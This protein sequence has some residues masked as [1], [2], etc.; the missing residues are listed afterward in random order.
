MQ[1]AGHGAG[2]G[3]TKGAQVGAGL[4]SGGFSGDV[5]YS[6]VENAVAASGIPSPAYPLNSLRAT[7]SDNSAVLAAAQQKFERLTVYGGYEH[8][9]YLPPSRTSTA[10]FLGQF[11]IPSNRPLSM[12]N[13]WPIGKP[14]PFGAGSDRVA[15]LNPTAA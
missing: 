8:I 1:V 9:N 4:D 12:R 5:V 3:S 7:L 10:P 11:A 15:A 2:N 6:W 13:R 14:D